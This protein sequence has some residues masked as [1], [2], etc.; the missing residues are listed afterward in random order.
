MNIVAIIRLLLNIVSLLIQRAD[1]KK[2]QEIG[3]DKQ[4]Q[5]SLQEILKRGELAKRIDLASQG[6]SSDDVDSVLSEYYRD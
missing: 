2:Q 1:D 3:R 5:N 6:Y 4:I